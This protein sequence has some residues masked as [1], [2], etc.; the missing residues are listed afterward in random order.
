M[1]VSYPHPPL[2]GG[3]VVLR[4]KWTVPN[5]SSNIVGAAYGRKAA[6]SLG[7]KYTEADGAEEEG[8]PRDQTTGTVGRQRMSWEV[9]AAGMDLAAAAAPI[10][11]TLTGGTTWVLHRKC[12]AQTVNVGRE[13]LGGRWAFGD[14]RQLVTR[15]SLETISGQ[16]LR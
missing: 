10:A 7:E 6:V 8:R 13:R 14:R 9:G 12:L 1:H 5:G 11:G 15:W 2:S 16:N 3:E 4:K